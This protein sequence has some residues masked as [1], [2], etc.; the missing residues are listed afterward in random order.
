MPHD[1][2]TRAETAKGRVPPSGFIRDDYTNQDGLRRDG[3]PMKVIASVA[4][5]E[6]TPP[7]QLDAALDATDDHFARS[8]RL[9]EVAERLGNMG[10]A[11]A[12]YSRHLGSGPSNAVSV[13]SVRDALGLHVSTLRS[14]RDF[15][16][17]G[18]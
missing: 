1:F 15:A 10:R 11:M 17:T 14:L 9:T 13:Y 5:D 3:E 2:S 8:K 12:E 7:E 6:C 18:K 16:E 4:P